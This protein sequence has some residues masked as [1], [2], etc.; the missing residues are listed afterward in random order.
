[1]EFLLGMGIGVALGS[2][3]VGGG[4]ALKVKP[5]NRTLTLVAAAFVLALLFVHVGPSFA[6]ETPVPLDIPVNDIFTETNNWMAVFAPIAAIGIGISI[7]LAIL[8][9]LGNMIRKAFN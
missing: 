6:Q 2:A 7:A 4:V 8:G 5:P 1:M 9:Y 3:I